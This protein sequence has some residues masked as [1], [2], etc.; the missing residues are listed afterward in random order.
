M[1]TIIKKPRVPWNK[2]IKLGPNLKCSIRMKGRIPW[3]KG[4]KTGPCPEH[5]K[6]MKGRIPWNK[7]VPNPD[8]KGKLPKNINSFISGGERTRF[9]KGQVSLRKGSVASEE[10][11]KKLSQNSYFRGKTGEKHW[12]WKGGL[13]RKQYPLKFNNLLKLKIRI[14]DN[15]TCCLCGR[16]EE[17]E[18][19][20]LDYVL[21]VNHI[22]FNKENCEEDNLNTLCRR[23]NVKINREREYWTN[24]FKEKMISKGIIN[25]EDLIEEDGEE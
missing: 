21:C 18:L 5:S 12:N 23:C 15:F 6:R 11:R 3:N 9:K 2:G 1:K 7:G 8:T 25:N 17:E 13:K 16:T 19:N 10:T 24:Y 20:E 14:R 22:D 4:I